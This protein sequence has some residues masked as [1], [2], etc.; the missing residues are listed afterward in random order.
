MKYPPLLALYIWVITVGGRVHTRPVFSA[1]A[2]AVTAPHP[3]PAASL[4]L[5]CQKKKVEALSLR[6]PHAHI[7]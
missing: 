4:I 5:F 6:Q 7:H 1:E 3:T 2:A